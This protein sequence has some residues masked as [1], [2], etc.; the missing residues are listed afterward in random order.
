MEDGFDSLLISLNVESI[1]TQV[2]KHLPEVQ[3]D[4]GKCL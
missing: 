1:N 4:L 3:T 2:D